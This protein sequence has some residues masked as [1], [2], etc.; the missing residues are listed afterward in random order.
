VRAFRL[1]IDCVYDSERPDGC[2]ASSDARFEEV[3][4][5][6]ESIEA[7]IS[8]AHVDP[9]AQATTSNGH[10]SP[11]I[12][13]NHD[14]GP[15]THKWSVDPGHLSRDYVGFLLFG[16]VFRIL[17]ENSTTVETLSESYFKKT[18][19]WLPMVCP[20]RFEEEH[21]KFKDFTPE[22]GFLIL[23]LAI[24]L[25]VTPYSKHPTSDPLADSP[26]YRACKFYFTQFIS[27]DEISVHLVQGGILLALF[28]YSHNIQNRALLTLGMAVQVACT[29]GLEDVVA[30]RTEQTSGEMSLAEE[31][32]VLTWWCLSLMSRYCTRQP[33]VNAVYSS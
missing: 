9:Q 2:D 10:M 24:H 19:K 4:R 6:L 17:S 12:N 31:E 28:E 8:S 27:M 5:R 7:R 25:T 18:H 11:F 13:G 26:W 30:E 21:K 15:Y 22:G 33:D 20:I 32:A 1:S 23:V 16:S 14:R 29:L 3:Y